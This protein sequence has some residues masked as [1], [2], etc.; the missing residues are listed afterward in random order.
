MFSIG[1][2]WKDNKFSCQ[3]TLRDGTSLKFSNLKSVLSKSQNGIKTQVL[4]LEPWME[5]LK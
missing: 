2:Y 4:Y 5:L 3:L 1:F